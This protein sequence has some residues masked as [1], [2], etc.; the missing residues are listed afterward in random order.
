MA[1][2]NRPVLPPALAGDA[3]FSALCDLLWEQHAALPLETLLLYLI[4]T[5]P[6]AALLPLAEQFHVMGAE[7][8][9]VAQTDGERRALIKNSIALHRTK[10]TVWA[11]KQILVTLGMTGVVSEWFD[12]GGQPYHFRIDVDLSGRGMGT[13][14]VQ[15]LSELVH[16]YK[17]AR[18][19]LEALTLNVSVR[20]QTPRI[21]AALYAG[22]V[23][24]VLPWRSTDLTQ[25]HRQYLAVACWSVEQV[26]LYPQEP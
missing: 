2:F 19:H 4:D 10:G 25:S 17:S 1:E 20:S 7:G 15:R 16:E 3:R 9:A 6:K 24:S 5:T 21:G 26:S 23:V 13:D 8:W 12:Y 14:E 11:I 18:S 22:E